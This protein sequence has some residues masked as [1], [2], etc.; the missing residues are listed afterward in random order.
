MRLWHGLDEVSLCAL[1]DFIIEIGST[2]V[3]SL[4]EVY[5]IIERRIKMR[6]LCLSILVVVV[7]VG[8]SQGIVLLEPGGSA[9]LGYGNYSNYTDIEK[10]SPGVAPQVEPGNYESIKYVVPIG[11]YEASFELR[12]PLNYFSV[13]SY[14]YE[15]TAGSGKD[16]H[17]AEYTVYSMKAGNVTNITYVKI[18]GTYYYSENGTKISNETTRQVSATSYLSLYIMHCESKK[19]APTYPYELLDEKFSVPDNWDVYSPQEITI[20]GKQGFSEWAADWYKDKLIRDRRYYGYKLDEN[21]FV[22]FEFKGDW[23][24]AK[25]TSLFL[26]TIHIKKSR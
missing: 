21:S 16:Y 10:A 1:A 17:I 8:E 9:W 15:E 22:A 4:P 13:R 12:S 14:P 11:P 7:F 3:F 6:C 5:H 20:D 26:E 2:K 19:Y 25:D 23:D 24:E 18:N